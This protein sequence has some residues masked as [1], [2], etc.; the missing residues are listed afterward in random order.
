ML[1]RNLITATLLVCL[2]AVGS[3]SADDLDNAQPQLE[4]LKAAVNVLQSNRRAVTSRACTD[5]LTQWKS[6][7]EAI[8]YDMV[9]HD[10]DLPVARDVLAMNYTDGARL[11]GADAARFCVSTP[12]ADGC[13]DFAAAFAAPAPAP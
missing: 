3:A 1:R 8:H 11:C 13:H 10:T 12:N 9:H 4:T 6:T 5:Q 2:H 7:M